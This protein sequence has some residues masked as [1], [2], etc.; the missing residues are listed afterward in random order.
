MAETGIVGLK[1][2]LDQFVAIEIDECD[3]AMRELIAETGLVEEQIRVAMM[4]WSFADGNGGRSESEEGFGRGTD[5][6]R[7]GVHRFSWN[8][9]DDVGFQQNRFSADVQIEEPES[10]IDE[11]VEFVRV[12]VCMQDCDR[13]SV[14]DGDP[15]STC[16]AVIASSSEQSR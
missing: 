5:E 2:R 3:L 14:S 11:F 15:E 7:I 12:L 9:F 10:L 1:L 8:V 16:A 4:P 13:V 6:L